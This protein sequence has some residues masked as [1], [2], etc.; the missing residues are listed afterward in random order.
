PRLL[1]FL[2]QYGVIKIGSSRN[3]FGSVDFPEYF[4]HFTPIANFNPKRVP[5]INRIDSQLFQFRPRTL[6]WQSLSLSFLS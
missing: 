2:F 4:S 1:F 3:K 6:T 5:T